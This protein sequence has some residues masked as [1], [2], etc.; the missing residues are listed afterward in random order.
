MI[1]FE[2]RFFLGGGGLGGVKFW[3]TKKFSL[4]TFLQSPWPDLT[5]NPL[6]NS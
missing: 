5:Q 4:N 3:Q 1:S 2:S 6:L